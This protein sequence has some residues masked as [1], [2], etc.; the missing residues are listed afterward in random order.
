MG[1]NRSTSLIRGGSIKLHAHSEG[2]LSFLW[3]KDGNPINGSHEEILVVKNPG[4]YSVMA[5]N[6]GC[7]SEMSEGMHVLLSAPD[8]HIIDPPVK[9]IDMSISK[10]ASKSIALLE[11]S[12]DYQL[13]VVNN[14]ADTATGVVVRDI[15][16]QA[17]E[18]EE[19]ISPY[20][21]M[22]HYLPSLRELTWELGRLLA[23]QSEELRIKTKLKETGPVK[24]DVEVEAEQVDPKLENNT[25]TALTQVVA[26]KIPN[27]FTPN[28]DGVNDFFEI[29]GLG[30]FAE[31]ELYVFN[32][33]GNEVFH[34]NHYQN[35]W[36]GQHLEEGTYYYALR[37]KMENGQWETFKGYLTLMRGK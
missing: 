18:Y 20:A 7:E 25:A 27:V 16:P 36:N 24:N 33:W 31:N 30:L 37:V 28:G 1:Q 22:V 15:L 17:L 13:I 6:G 21:G 10:K 19:A 3:F 11:S 5:L 9:S 14:S 32:R 8:D 35:N 34:Q 4:I 26:L 12:I 29:V 23:G 2:A